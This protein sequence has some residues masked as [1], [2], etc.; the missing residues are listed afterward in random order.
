MNTPMKRI[1][2]VSV[3]AVLAVAPAQA[4]SFADTQLLNYAQVNEEVAQLRDQMFATLDDEA[5][6]HSLVE[7]KASM[8]DQIDQIIEA[9]ALSQ[10]DYDAIQTA[11]RDDE[12][13]RAHYDELVAQ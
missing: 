5:G 9:S 8:Q 11:L 3:F 1:A 4:N 10:S 7:L 12:A 13:L 6:Q 2:A